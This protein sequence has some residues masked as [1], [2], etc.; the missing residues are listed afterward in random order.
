M[1]IPSSP[2]RHPTT[3]TL[4]A[5]AASLAVS[6]CAAGLQ[7]RVVADP[8]G[9]GVKDAN[10]TVTSDPDGMHVVSKLKTVEQGAYRLGGLA[11]GARYYV[12]IAAFGFEEIKDD[13]VHDVSGT[14][15]WTHHLPRKY[16]LRGIVRLPDGRVAAGAL[17][18]VD[19]IGAGKKL[20]KYAGD[21]GTFVIPEITKGTYDLRVE[22]SEGYVYAQQGRKLPEDGLELD[23]VL[24]YDPQISAG[25]AGTT[26]ISTTTVPKDPTAPATSGQ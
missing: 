23:L 5:L 9:W 2:L 24:S 10:V 22:S 11:P 8:G 18:T 20:T 12:W 13:L 6:A 19:K 7:G 17:I 1:L 3:R 16:E 25:K 4:L 21:D 15:K 14:T 26:A